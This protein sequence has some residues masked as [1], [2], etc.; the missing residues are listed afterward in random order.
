[1]SRKEKQLFILHTILIIYLYMASCIYF[2]SKHESITFMAV[3]VSG[4]NFIRKE[5]K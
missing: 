2:Q 4:C 3:L 1:M 5:E